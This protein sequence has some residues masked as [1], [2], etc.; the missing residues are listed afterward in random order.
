LPDA[1]NPFAAWDEWLKTFSQKLANVTGSKI[2]TDDGVITPKKE[3]PDS[4]VPKSTGMNYFYSQ[5]SMTS[6][7]EQARALYAYMGSSQPIV[8]QIDGKEIASAVQNQSLSGNDP[9][10]NRLL[11]GFR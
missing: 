2:P 8:V 7:A 11:G 4:N 1:K 9:L 5:P 6:T 3:I 10:V